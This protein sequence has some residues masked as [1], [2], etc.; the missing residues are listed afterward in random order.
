MVTT[1]PAKFALENRVQEISSDNC[2]SLMKMIKMREILRRSTKSKALQ[3]RFYARVG[4][5]EI[6]N[7]AT[8]DWQHQKKA[9]A[10]IAETDKVALENKLQRMQV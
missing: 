6:D 4:I 7:A 2:G 3:E 9:S 10:G 1:E 5:K 8:E